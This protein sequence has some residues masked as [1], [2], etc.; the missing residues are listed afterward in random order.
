MSTSE[1]ITTM[2]A[3]LIGNGAALL[4]AAAMLTGWLLLTIAIAGVARP[5]IVWP[6]SL[7]LLCC[8]AAGWNLLARV[9]FFGL[10]DLTRTKEPPR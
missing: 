5:R 9:V 4:T 7:G 2:R 10:Y 8:S 1:R 6:A 3:W